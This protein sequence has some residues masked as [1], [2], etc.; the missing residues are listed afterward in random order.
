[1]RFAKSKLWGKLLCCVK[2]LQ[3][4]KYKKTCQEKKQEQ[5]SFTAKWQQSPD[6][7]TTW[8]NDLKPVGTHQG[9]L[10]NWRKLS[11]ITV[12]DQ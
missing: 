10:G 11:H 2:K 6:S 3:A 7:L 4:I 12:V 5:G 9:E 8:C 1:M